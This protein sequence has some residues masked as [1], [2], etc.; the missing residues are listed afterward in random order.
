MI[1]LDLVCE[2]YYTA[3]TVFKLKIIVNKE[4]IESYVEIHVT[5]QFFKARHPQGRFFEKKLFKICSWG[6]CVQNFMS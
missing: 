3:L 5:R 1:I 6:V 4:A 2:L